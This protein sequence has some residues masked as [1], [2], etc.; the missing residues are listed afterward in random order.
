[1]RI[2]ALDP[3]K[4]TGVCLA[5]N[6]RIEETRE[7]PTTTGGEFHE[8]LHVME[9][10]WKPDLVICEQFLHRTT[11]GVDTTALEVIGC[12][13]MFVWLQSPME[14]VFQTPSMAKAFWTDDKLKAVG[15]WRKGQRH[16]M[17]ATRHALAYLMKSDDRYIRS[18][19]P[20]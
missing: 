6:G 5:I 19:S 1:M 15:L 16:A 17:D 13:K 7:T 8:L 4:T 18:L 2:L 11:I 12:V 20:Q 10:W 3:G 9:Y 14:L